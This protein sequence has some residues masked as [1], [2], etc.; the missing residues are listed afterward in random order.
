MSATQESFS[1]RESV[2]IDDVLVDDFSD[3]RFRIWESSSAPTPINANPMA[4]DFLIQDVSF[5]N[6]GAMLSFPCAADVPDKV[7]EATRCEPIAQS[8]DCA[9]N[10]SLP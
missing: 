2:C 7:V 8:D 1:F 5:S 10:A 4:N 9:R 6:V 3:C